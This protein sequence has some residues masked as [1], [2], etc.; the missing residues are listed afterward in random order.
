MNKQT[1]L[2]SPLTRRKQISLSH[3]RVILWAISFVFLFSFL[4]VPQ[5]VHAGFLDNIDNVNCMK[6][7][8]CTLDDVAEGFVALTELLIGSIGALALVYFIWGGIQWLTSYGNQQKIQKGREIMLQTVIALIIAFMSYILVTFFI[9]N[10]L[11]GQVPAV[12]NGANN[13]SESTQVAGTHCCVGFDENNNPECVITAIQS[14]CLPGYNENGP[15]DCTN[16]VMC[17]DNW[18]GQAG[19]C[20]DVDESNT[21]TGCEYQNAG[22]ICEFNFAPD[23]PCDSIPGCF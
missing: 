11:Q 8:D 17:D 6:S 4:A 22:S 1:S 19:C 15:G 2:F 7:G 16:V 10:I 5:F 12:Q 13:S 14:S 18:H 20:V 3:R 21:I 9:D 23:T